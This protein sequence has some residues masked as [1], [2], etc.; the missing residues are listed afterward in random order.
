MGGYVFW[1][2]EEVVRGDGQQ[3]EYMTSDKHHV[4]IRKDGTYAVES[5]LDNNWYMRVRLIKK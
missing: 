2:K 1:N 5:G 3:A 4:R